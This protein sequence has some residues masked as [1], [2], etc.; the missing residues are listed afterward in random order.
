MPLPEVGAVANAGLPARGYRPRTGARKATGGKID[1]SLGGARPEH[2]PPPSR[3]IHAGS[4]LLAAAHAQGDRYLIP[5][6]G[7]VDRA[8]RSSRPQQ[9]VVLAASHTLSHLL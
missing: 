4:D 7:K 2:S 5:R 3:A 8:L 1:D 9:G 6:G